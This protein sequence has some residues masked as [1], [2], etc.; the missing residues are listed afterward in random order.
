[1]PVKKRGA[2]NAQVPAGQADRKRPF[3]GY[4]FLAV[5]KRVT[6]RKGETQSQ[7]NTEMLTKKVTRRLDKQ[8]A[9]RHE[10]LYK[11]AKP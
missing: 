2:Y 4:S 10:P 1:M 6:R 5:V 7:I 11:H 3:S 9:I 8:R